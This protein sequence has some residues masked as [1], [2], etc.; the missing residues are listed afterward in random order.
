LS[1]ELLP[2]WSPVPIESVATNACFTR[3]NE[4][5]QVLWGLSNADWAWHGRMDFAAIQMRDEKNFYG[6]SA[7]KV[8]H[9]GN[10]CVVLWQVPPWAIDERARPYLRTSK[11]HSYRVAARILG[12]MG[13]DFEIPLTERFVRPVEK[14]WLHSFYIDTPV[15]ED[16]PYR[17]YRW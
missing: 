15:A 9:Y 5:P 7:L 8:I 14:A 17:Y 16:D 10:G 1:A 3:I 6:N 2:G 4:L 13:A 12:N 11:R